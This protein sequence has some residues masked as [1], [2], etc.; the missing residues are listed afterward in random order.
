MKLWDIILIV[1]GVIA[2]A[3]YA[4]ISVLKYKNDKKNKK[5]NKGE[6]NGEEY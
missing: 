6:E 4:T 2:V 1:C 5:E 3:T